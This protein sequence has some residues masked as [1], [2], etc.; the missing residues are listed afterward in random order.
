MYKLT[1]IDVFEFLLNDQLCLGDRWFITQLDQPVSLSPASSVWA[2]IY[3]PGNLYRDV[4]IREDMPII[5]KALREINPAFSFAKSY[6]GQYKNTEYN[7][8]LASVLDTKNSV[9]FRMQLM[10]GRVEIV[11]LV[12]A[13]NA[14]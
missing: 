9:A 11:N 4:I 6:L 1:L 7:I 12:R 14:S 10:G 5:I 2:F 13:N 3:R 8:G